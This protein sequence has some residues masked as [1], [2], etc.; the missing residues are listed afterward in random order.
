MAA[1]THEAI[2]QGLAKIKGWSYEGK[3]L[4]KKFTFKSFLPGI[5]FVNKIAAAAESA[6]H[7]PGLVELADR[8]QG[9]RGLRGARTGHRHWRKHAQDEVAR[10][11]GRV[12]G[13]AAAA[14]G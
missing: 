7:H 4:H 3:E 1:L 11:A 10:R 6:G 5:E 8:T 9:L 13:A 2:Q 12:A 14:A